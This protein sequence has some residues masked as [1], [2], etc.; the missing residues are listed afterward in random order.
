MMGPEFKV[1]V[2]KSEKCHQVFEFKRHVFATFF[3]KPTYW[4]T[5]PLFD[6]KPVF[7]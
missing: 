7:D 4:P 1:Y 2:I 3:D 6:G 5:V